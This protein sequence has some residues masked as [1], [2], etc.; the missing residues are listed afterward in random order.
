[1]FDD[2]NRPLKEA[3]PSIPME[4]LGLPS[5]PEA[6]ERFY[7]V[8]DERTAR[9]I[10]GKRQEEI[11]T[12]KFQLFQKITLEDLYSQIQKGA[13]KELNV[14]MKSDVQGSLEALKDSLERI[15]SDKIKLK[16]IHMGVGDVNLSDVLLAVASGAI[17][18]AFHVSVEARAKRELELHP[19]DIRE[20]RIIYDAVNDI[21]N[22]LE[23]MLEAKT[24]KKSI[25]RIEIRQVMK[26]SKAG[27]VAGCYVQKGRVSRKALVDVLRNDEVVYSGKISSLKRF[28]DDVRE[29][30]EGMECG[31]TI[32]GFD[33]IEAGDIIEAFELEMIAQKL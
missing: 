2:L 16:F 19:V 14:I 10:T 8:A 12:R 7:V 32:D 23:G 13:I 4:F 18:I 20:Y 33:K 22:A 21:R 3:G 1:M 26:L 11:K 15:P 27:I 30:T 31:I 6:G 5:V 9:D 28:K 29:V 25:S 17:I 24:R